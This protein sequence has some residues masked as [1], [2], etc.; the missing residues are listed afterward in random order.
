LEHFWYFF[1]SPVAGTREPTHFSGDE[2]FAAVRPPLMKLSVQQRE[3]LVASLQL[4]GFSTP[5]L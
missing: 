3:Q 1:R 5:G 4:L 2:G